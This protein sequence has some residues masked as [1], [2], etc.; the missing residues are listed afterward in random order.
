[1]AIRPYTFH[2]GVQKAKAEK[3]NTF[4]ADDP[5]RGGGTR[6]VSFAP[7]A[8]IGWTVFAERDKRSVLLSEWLYYVQVIVIA[9]LLFVTFVLLLLYFRKQIAVQQTLEQLEAEK[10]IRASQERTERLAEEMVI[11]AEI[12]RV[13]GSTLEIEKVYESMADEIGKLIPFDSLI[14]NL[15]DAQEET[16]EVGYASGLDIPGRRVGDVFSLRGTVVEEAIRTRRGLIVQSENPADLERKFP[17]LRISAEAGMLSIMSVPLIAGDDVIGNLV[18]RINKPLA[19]AERDLLLAEKIGMQI[20][21]AVAN[22]RLFR[23]LGKAENMIHARLRLV[24]FAAHH[25]LDELLQQTLDEVCAMTDSPIGFYHFVEPDQKTLSLQAWSTRTRQEYCTAEGK[26]LHYGVDQAGVW[27]DCIRQRQPVIHNDYASLPHRKGL[28]EGHAVLVRELVVPI[29]REGSIVAVLGIGN[30]AQDYTENDIGI[31]TYFA[32]VAWEIA[33]RKKAD[34]TLLALSTR[35]QALLSAIP[36]IVMEVDVDKVYTW[37]NHPGYDFFGSDVIGKEAAFYFEGEQDTYDTVSPLFGGD[38]NTIYVES[39]QRRKDGQ[40]RLLAWWCRVLKN[41]SGN[42]IGA[43]SSA[44]DITYQKMA[45]EEILKLNIQLEQRVYERTAQLE[46]ANRELEAFS[47][48]VSHDL[49][50]PL[51]S[52]NGFSQALLDDYRDKLDEAGKSYLERVCNAA[53]RMG[54]QIDDMI[55]LSKVLKSEFKLEAIDLSG[56]I[57]AIDEAR[58][59]NNPNRAIDLAVQEGVI[60]RGDPHLMRIVL[61]NLMDNA[62]K[63]TGK[64]A[65]PRIEFGATE[66]GGKPVCFVRDNGVGFDMAYAGKLFGAFQR[67]H[68]MDEFAGSGIGLATVKR[69]INRH[70]GRIWA[71]GEVGKGATFYFTIP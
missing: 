5:D 58:R 53:Q 40:K 26:G 19:Y 20:S 69:I 55:M 22:A 59:E 42:V 3:S 12:G 64:Q 15:R 60:V 28:P 27:V 30:K 9:F 44:R 47:Y 36:D 23:D 35:Q 61:E 43:L 71:E 70:G 21:G 2:P 38:E 48:S 10:K 1:L 17:S 65:H 4:T 7:V 29:F 63:F 31:V 11:I 62:F 52:I 41:E 49:R 57:R 51:R 34:E 16:L 18:L 50:A 33:R 37:A 14:V 13:I 45:E 32:D 8:G 67:L 54:V 56:M 24:E 39:W 68:T 25:S 66:R 6:Y 46:A